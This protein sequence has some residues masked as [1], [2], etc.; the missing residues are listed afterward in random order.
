MEIGKWKLAQS[1]IHHPEPKDSRGVWDDLVKVANA[2]W[3]TKERDQMGEGGQAGHSPLA[4]SQFPSRRVRG[5][6]PL[7]KV[8]YATTRSGRA[9]GGT[10][11]LVQPGPGRPGYGGKRKTPKEI[12]QFKKNNIRCYRNPMEGRFFILPN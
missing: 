10:P 8:S 12:A 11:Q 1:W 7:R 5:G 6:H 2:E 9:E 4:V 3:E